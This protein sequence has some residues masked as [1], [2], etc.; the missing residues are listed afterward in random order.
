M[1]FSRSAFNSGWAA[2]PDNS[3]GAIW[4]M[5][6]TILFTGMATNI[7]L[8][9]Q[10]FDSFQ[11]VFFRCLFHLLT[12]LPF[13]IR[14]GGWSVVRTSRFPLHVLRVS[15]GLV[16]MFCGF[17]AFVNLTLA[18][19][20]AISFARPL[21]MI[22]LAV[23]FL[24]E[25]V[26]MRRWSA[27]IVGFIGVVVMLRP[28]ES[29]ISTAALVALL[30]AFCVA[31]VL[32]I[33]KRLS[34][35]ERPLTISFWFGVIATLVSAVPAFMV[36]KEPT[37][38]QVFWLA[39]IGALGATAQY[40]VI[41]AYRIGEATAVAPFDYIRLLL[42]ALVGWLVFAEQPDIWTGVGSVLIIGSTLYI[43]RREA[44]RK[45]EDV[46][47][48]QSPASTSFGTREGVGASVVAKR[49]RDAERKG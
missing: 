22:P 14:E 16:A 29:A 9:G 47:G 15:L 38:E 41:R 46:N 42:A 10:H 17:Y 36:W 48:T 32:V 34:T 6:S 26:R 43:A 1:T 4:L 45:K 27:T 18:D 5:L 24:H 13:V 33:I 11:I 25:V 8:M 35:T 40:M 20:V 30:G 19:A 3:R 39:L 21:F 12:I 2:L 23:I 7:K 37:L 31:V 44:M 28:G 49:E